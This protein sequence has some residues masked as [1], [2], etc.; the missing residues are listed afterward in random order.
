M[1]KLIVLMFGAALLST[2]S[3]FA[4]DDPVVKESWSELRVVASAP[5]PEEIEN[6]TQAKAL[7]QEAAVVRGQTAFIKY[8]ERK[9][10]RSKKTLAVAEYPYLDLQ[11]KVQNYIKGARV[12]RTRW[13]PKSCTVTLVLSKKAL[14]EILRKN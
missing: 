13:T 4:N 6:Q 14:N 11:A 7:A 9:K 10:T 2:G 8:I 1:R 5:I 12:A 3:V